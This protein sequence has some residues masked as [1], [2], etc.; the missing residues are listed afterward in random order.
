VRRAKACYRPQKSD[1]VRVTPPEGSMSIKI[2]RW[3]FMTERNGWREF[4]T[5]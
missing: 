5:N 4:P 3:E 2:A 1:P